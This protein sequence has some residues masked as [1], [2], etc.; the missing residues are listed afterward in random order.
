MDVTLLNTLGRVWWLVLLRGIAAIV[1]GILALAW[2]GVT[3]VSL[4]LLWGAWALVDGV[5]ALVAGWKA[6][7][8]TK[9]M[10][11]I[12]L[13]GLV[14]I[15]AGVLTFLMPGVTAIALLIMIAVWA[16]VSGVFQIIAA[17]RLRKEI[18][19]EWMLI[20]SGALS[21]LFGALMIISPGAGALAVLW[22]IGSFA[23]AFG[24][25][26]VILAFRLRKHAV[27]PTHA[28]A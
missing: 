5:T 15:A 24:A 4:V 14:G 10:W 20:L 13:V 25:L 18:A 8:G 28:G 27:A 26:L 22:V 1:F 2:P 7:D 17:I 3:L 23:I 19:N 16:I 9:P 6:R 11:Q 21:V 12:V